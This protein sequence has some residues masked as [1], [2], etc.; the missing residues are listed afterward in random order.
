MF[1]FIT[2]SYMNLNSCGT[3]NFPIMSYFCM[4]SLLNMPLPKGK[5]RRKLGGSNS[6]SIDSSH[7]GLHY[8]ECHSDVTTTQNETN[9]LTPRS[10]RWIVPLNGP[11][12]LSNFLSIH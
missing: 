8:G 11:L 12:I 5:V 6:T 10:F 2:L 4:F 1:N 7:F 9:R 3:S